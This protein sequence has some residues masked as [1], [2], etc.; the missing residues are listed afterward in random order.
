MKPKEYI[1]ELRRD[2]GMTQCELGEIL[3]Y[4]TGHIAGVE[5]GRCEITAEFAVRFCAVTGG[6]EGRAFPAL[7]RWRRGLV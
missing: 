3:G 5:Q 6:D 2:A 1:R 4:S 7:R